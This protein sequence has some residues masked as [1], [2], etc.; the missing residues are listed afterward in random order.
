MHAAHILFHAISS[1]LV[2]CFSP[3]TL[4]PV[5]PHVCHQSHEGLFSHSCLLPDW[6][7]VV[8]T[9]LPCRGGNCCCSFMSLLSCQVF[10]LRQCHRQMQQQAATAQAAAAA[11]AAA[12]AGNIPGP[13][14]VGGIAPA[15][16]KPLY[17]LMHI[18]RAHTQMYIYIYT[19]THTSSG[20]WRQHGSGSSCH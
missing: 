2:V 5:L 1:G 11:Q 7:P 15:I 3:E 6:Q 10:D 13:G 19:H 16:S 18:A 17:L 9:F 12:V 20:R 14:S 4:F 8:V